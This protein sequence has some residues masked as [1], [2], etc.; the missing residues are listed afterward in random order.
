MPQIT[1]TLADDVY[2]DLTHN[3]PKGLKSK[4]V[5][6]AVQHAIIECGGSGQVM[7]KYAKEGRHAAH[8][9]YNWLLAAKNDGQTKLGMGWTATQNEETVNEKWIREQKE[10][11]EE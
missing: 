5:T 7:H 6:R 10:A 9:L 1:V 8:E 4:F 11:N 3:L 2:M